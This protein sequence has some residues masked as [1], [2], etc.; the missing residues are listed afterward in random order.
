MRFLKN[1]D[2][3]ATPLQRHKEYED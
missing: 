3:I 1:W 2:R